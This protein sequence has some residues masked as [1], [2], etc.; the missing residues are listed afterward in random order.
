MW[1]TE[2]NQ[3][4]NFR[5]GWNRFV[6][7][8]GDW[9]FVLFNMSEEKKLIIE[10]QELNLIEAGFGDLVNSRVVYKICHHGKWNLDIIKLNIDNKKYT[11]YEGGMVMFANKEIL[12]EKSST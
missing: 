7:T 4:N 12:V 11:I 6:T 2:T 8:D 3:N 1:F 10:N 5:R 9:E